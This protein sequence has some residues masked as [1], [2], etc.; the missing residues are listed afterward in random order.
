LGQILLK[1]FAP[2]SESIN[3][4]VSGN[5]DLWRIN[6]NMGITKPNLLIPVELQVRELE[7]KLLLACVAAKR[8]FS[9]VI[10]HR[11]EMHFHIPSFPR[12]IYLSKSTT[13][14]SKKVFKNLERL[15]AKIVVWD[16]EALV[17]LP[18]KLYYRHR[19]SPLTIGYVSHLFAWGEENAELWQ[20]YPNLPGGI[21][22]HITGNP[23]GDLLRPEL[24][25]YYENDVNELRKA[26]GDFILVNTNFNLV[27]AYYPDMNL[28]TPSPNPD[29]GLILSRR[30]KSLGLSR[31]YA[32]GFTE[33]KRAIL[34]DF[35][36]LIPELDKSFPDYTIIVR[37]HP[38]ENQEGY[39]RIAEKCE[40]VRV[41]NKGNVVPWLLASKA[42]IHNGCTT[43]IEAYALGVPALAYKVRGHDRYDRDFHL[44]PNQLSHECYNFEELQATLEQILVGRLGIAGGGERK[45]LMN[46]HLAAQDG[47]LACE[48]IIDVLEEI[49]EE[50]SEMPKP[51]LHDLLKSWGWATKR[52]VKKRFRGYRQNMSHN[53]PEF[54]RHRYPEISQE[55]IRNRVERFHELLGHDNK[56]SVQQFG[57]Q[58]FRI[59]NRSN[60]NS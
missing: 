17:A 9:S 40:R 52:R 6:R 26:Y 54:L 13:N 43:G 53:R 8:G 32:E 36:G 58:F 25:G 31:E 55:E 28:L 51:T 14:A 10:G 2:Y 34:G 47:P 46:R 30:S 11:R 60:S 4:T 45:A 56:L 22:I 29:E 38:V 57:G 44:L 12:S 7:P 3:S 27:N 37:P 23:R 39:H 16:E 50:M 59:T 18:P 41:I 21:P 35:E 33:Y 48:R 5:T 24:R 20:Q 42:L 19:L 49:T 1:Q 15:H